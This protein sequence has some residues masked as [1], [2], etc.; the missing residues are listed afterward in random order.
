MY[1]QVFAKGFEPQVIGIGEFFGFDDLYRQ[2]ITG[3]QMYARP[4]FLDPEP[5]FFGEIF[6]ERP[7]MP[8]FNKGEGNVGEACAGGNG[9]VEAGVGIDLEKIL[10][11]QVVTGTFVFAYIDGP[12]D[13]GDIF[14]YLDPRRLHDDQGVY[15]E[16]LAGKLVLVLEFQHV[17][18]IGK[19]KLDSL[20]KSGMPMNIFM[21]LVELR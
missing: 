2:I 4:A 19:F 7:G 11:R 21:T 6:N 17:P 18:V 8:G 20:K 15:P 3:Y 10:H 1:C 5:A 12:E 13:P 14:V 9:R 16:G